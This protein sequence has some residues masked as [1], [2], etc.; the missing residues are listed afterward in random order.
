MLTYCDL[1]NR[2]SMYFFPFP[3]HSS[4]FP[5][6][7]SPVRAFTNSTLLSAF[8]PVKQQANLFYV[9]VNLEE[10][11]LYHGNTIK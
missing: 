1:V 9:L 4:G 2:M 6:M 7:P 11:L 3:S 5:T 10:K 8:Y